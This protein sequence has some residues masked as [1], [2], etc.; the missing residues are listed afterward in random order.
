MISIRTA[1]R[2][3]LYADG[4]NGGGPATGDEAR[5]HNWP[6]T[7]PGGLSRIRSG[8][9]SRDGLYGANHTALR[10]RCSAS[11]R[12]S[13]PLAAMNLTSSRER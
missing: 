2:V 4:V 7:V 5:F 13:H 8:S 10:R 9:P 3:E 12:R 1:V 11:G 6:A